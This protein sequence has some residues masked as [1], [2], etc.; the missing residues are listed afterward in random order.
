MEASASRI[1]ETSLYRRG[2]WITALARGISLGLG[3]VA[4]YLLWH[5]PKT[6][7]V[8][9]L[10]VGILYLVYS[11]ASWV[12]IRR[13]PQNRAL[14]VAHDVADALAVGGGA[15]CS[16][17]LESPVWLL[18][19]P[20]VVAVS[21]RGG[22][23]YALAM[24]ALDALIVGG[25]VT[26]AQPL[27]A[28]HA[29][30]LLFCAFVG[31]TASSYLHGIQARLSHA[32]DRL[33]LQNVQLSETFAAHETARAQQEAAM[34]LL[35]E[36]ETRYRLLLDR[37]ADANR[38]LEEL[39]QLREQYLRNVSHEFRT[40]LT[41]IRGYA[42]YLMD[43]GGPEDASRR[44]VMRIIMESCDRVID[45]VDTLIEV[46]RIEQGVASRTLQVEDLDLRE[47]V[48]ASVDVLRPAAAKKGI[49]VNL[50][51]P[52]ERLRF[53]GDGGLLRQVVRKLLDNA[54]KYSRAGARVVIRGREE[55]GELR[56]E[57]EDSGIGIAPE[58]LPRIFEKFYTVDGGLARRG[59]GTG[60]GLYLVREIVRLHKGSVE[61]ESHPGQ[62]SLFHV[63]L[64]RQFQ[65]SRPQTA[66][67]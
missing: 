9:A 4:L 3:F 66:L 62:G 35:R 13:R 6:R 37:M 1:L 27:G 23:R 16:G 67:A 60:V 41:V 58:H 56:L 42:E 21:V 33:T 28:L 12:L 64:P 50:E 14:K 20:H 57:V 10:L 65:G 29:L 55:S 18:L 34:A 26:P 43:A 45:M 25:L 48:A 54:L 38:R 15:V 51:F 22:L 53:E 8:P 44:D 17:G 61:V 7:A 47:L 2:Q 36:S 11:V 52:G 5:S 39:D 24:G 40:P 32:Y 19:Y 31:G 49:A 46:S 63:R 59:G 30:A